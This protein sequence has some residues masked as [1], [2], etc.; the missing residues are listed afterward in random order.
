MKTKY[1]AALILAVLLAACGPVVGGAFTPIRATAPVVT[2]VPTSAPI[3]A[4][5][6]AVGTAAPVIISPLPPD[7]TPPPTSPPPTL[8][9]IPT[10][11]AGLSPT[12][13]K[14]QVL[15]QF[16]NLFFCDPDY[17]PVARADEADLARQRF[18]ELQANIE[19]LNAI[20]AHNSLSGAT[21]F[22]DEQKLIVYR[23]HKKLNAILFNLS[24][25]GYEFQL[26]ISDNQQEGFLVQGLID[27]AGRITVQQK[28]PTIATCPICLAADT[29]VDTPA[30]PIAVSELRVG[31]TVWTVDE[32]GRR[33]AAPILEVVR[34][35]APAAHRVVHLKLSD[36]RELWASPGHPTADGRELGDLQRGDR[37]DGAAITFIERAPYDQIS[38]YDLMPARAT[39]DNWANGILIGSTLSK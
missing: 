25:D 37:L 39:G 7:F 34:V 24:G 6:A 1:L 29:R 21:N 35:T 17:Y 11:R 13:L 33:V 4:V 28:T 3:T 38:T 16:P 32:A 19:E 8:T 5:T 22:T 14:Y 2:P 26:Q 15:A 36:G 31:M 18:P 9:A 27:S 12:E 10:L 30:G 23:E 20:L